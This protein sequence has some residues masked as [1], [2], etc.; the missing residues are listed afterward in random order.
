MK[1]L[2]PCPVCLS[3]PE[4]ADLFLEENIDAGKLTDYSFASRKVPEFM[5]HRLARCR[6]CDHVYA[7]RPPS[8]DETTRAYHSAQYDS[9]DEAEDAAAAY[10]R[11][12]L[13]ILAQLKHRERALEIGTGNGIFLEHLT[14]NGFEEVIGVEP[15][16][17]AIGAA[18]EETRKW[19][20]EG[21]FEENHFDPASFDLICCFMT[22]EHV[23]DPRLIASA[24]FRL[25]RPGGA[26]VSVVHD[27]RGRVNKLLGKR[28]PI[29]DIEHLQ[30]FSRA[31][32]HSLYDRT[33]Y[34]DIGVRGYANEYRLGYWN[35]LMPLPS[36]VKALI[37]GLLDQTGLGRMKVSIDVGNLMVAGFK[38]V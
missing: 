19:I 6:I 36:S 9:S 38:P 34:V 11:A 22:M 13:P 1:F 28:S 31:S 32:I 4:H 25:L 27:Y 16:L 5:C 33:G 24:A 3:G 15:S 21:V 26:F 20:R 7:D 8:E 10:A 2:R 29:I 14:R 37:G 18:T 17:S 23:H 30:L 35:R 12:I